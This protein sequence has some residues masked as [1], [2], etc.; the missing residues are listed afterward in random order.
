MHTCAAGS[1]CVSL[2][3]ED[4]D[5]DRQRSL[6]F[7]RECVDLLKL[8]TVY[9]SLQCYEAHFQQHRETVHLPG[10]AK[11]HAERDDANELLFEDVAK[12]RYRARNVRGGV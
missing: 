7:C 11:I 8:P 9:C 2:Q 1:N 3:D 12:S 6:V 5:M 10:R 4:V